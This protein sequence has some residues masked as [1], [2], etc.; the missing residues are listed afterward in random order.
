MNRPGSGPTMMTRQGVDFGVA[1]MTGLSNG[2]R[3]ATDSL[4][5][6]A[7]GTPATPPT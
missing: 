5:V 1:P 3:G 6:R 4:A 2:R 7:F